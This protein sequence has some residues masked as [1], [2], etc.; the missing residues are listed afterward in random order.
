[1]SLRKREDKPLKPAGSQE[2]DSLA[3]KS[4]ERFEGERPM[5]LSLYL[6][7]LF[8]V[9][10]VVY[11]PSG[12]PVEG[13]QVACGEQTRTT[14]AQ[15]GF[16]MPSACEATVTKPGFVPVRVSLAESNRIDLPLAS[17][18]DRIVVT[19]A[20]APIAIEEA[21]V[22]ADVFTAADFTPPHVPFVQDLLRDVQGVD[23]VQTGQNGALTSVFMRGGNFNG[24]LVLLDGVPVS[25]PGGSMDFA[26][27]TSAGL[28]R[29]EV[30]R[31]PESAL[32]GA[33]AA[34]GVIQMFTRHGDPESSTP[35]GEAV[36]ERGSFSTDHWSAL[37]DGGLAKRFD[38]ALSADQY[39]S[40][41]EF[42][43]DAYR[44]TTGTANLGYRFSEK[45][46]I[47]ASY[48][49]FDSYT[50]DPGQTADQ[51]FDLLSHSLDR[52]STVSVRLDDA[53]TAHFAQRFTYGYHRYRDAYYDGFDPA[54]IS[55]AD[56]NLAAYQGTW[57]HPGGT[58]VFGY[59]FQHQ[60]GFVSEVDRER[61]NN[62]W[63]GYE[64]YSIGKRI[65]LAG[66]AR[67]EHS[68]VFGTQFSPRGAA[69]FRLPTDTYFR[70]SA[71]RGI[72]E[73]SLL[74]NF[75]R[76]AYFV[77]NPSLKPEKT[78]S[79]EAGLFHEFF[80]RRLRAEASFFR[81]SF[82]DLIQFDFSSFPGTWANIQQAWARGLEVSGSA[83][84]LKV[85]SVRG[86]YTRLCTRITQ[87]NNAGQIGTQLLRRPLNSGAVSIEVAPRRWTF[88]FGARFIGERADGDFLRPTV[89]RNPAYNYLFLNGS[90]QAT[91]HVSPFV[92]I[93][94]LL[95]ESY[96]EALGYAALSRNAAGGLRV[97]F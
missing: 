6:F 71:A 16:E 79:Y 47:R 69:T 51:S 54:S 9:R 61:D 1:L 30:I 36:Y 89:L 45:T 5:S 19:A 22:A 78:I 88:A 46:Q 3:R 38:Y 65:F 76:E 91:R 56:R 20:A 2:T 49:E 27:L 68:T 23:V 96:Q 11:D 55:L 41:G 50:G 84:I 81:N 97:T 18:S 85:I 8:Q 60:S 43:N 63:F 4:E 39:R 26:H 28:D 21:G 40:T 82:R 58:L 52:D 67:I 34:S 42:P 44:I 83:R 17:T 77:G 14:D 80:S 94:N 7:F 57:T 90:W 64:Q 87:S 32:F 74:E 92:R 70:V 10:G 53:R 48:R 95:D 29:M 37:L 31:G 25:D 15:G 59:E 62:G 73:P 93:G 24:A 72:Q 13:A 75:A 33:E 12:R 35:H 66:G 86:G